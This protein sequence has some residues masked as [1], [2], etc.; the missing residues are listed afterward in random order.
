MLGV[1]RE[2]LSAATVPIRPRLVGQPAPGFRVRHDQ[3]H[4]DPPLLAVAGRPQWLSHLH[5][6]WTEPIDLQGARGTVVRQVRVALG[7][8]S[9]HGGAHDVLV[10]VT[11]PVEPETSDATP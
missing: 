9:P 6:L 4:S 7:G 2:T 3:V 10:T 5:V 8:G 11:I 1:E